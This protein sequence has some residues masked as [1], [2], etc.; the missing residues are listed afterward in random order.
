MADRPFRN[1][2]F[3]TLRSAYAV[4][5]VGLLVTPG[6]SEA[7]S[8]AELLRR[9]VELLVELQEADGQ[10]AY[11]GV[12]RVARQIPVG[13]RVGGTAIVA[14]TLLYA[15][16]NDSAAKAAIARAIPFVLK[17]LDD[18][19]MVPSTEEGYD[20]RVW[21]HACA[22][23]FL[24]HLRAAGTAGEHAAAVAAWI[25]K[26][27]ATLVTEE[28]SG[29]GWNYASRQRHASFV[30]APVTQALLLA[31]SQGEKVP[32]EVLSRARKVLEA[33]RSSVG[34]FAYSGTGS[35]GRPGDQVPGSAARSAVCE[36]TL[37]LLGGGSLDAVRA[38]ID[39]FHTNWDE[40]KKRHQQTG[41]HVP[42]YMIAPYYFYYGHRYA[43]QAIEMLPE[44][45]RAKER[46]RL[47]SVILK[48][49]D[50]DGTW[51]DR[52]FPR[53]RAYGTAMC[54]VAL[55]G[56]QVPLPPRF[57]PAEQ[58][59]QASKTADRGEDKAKID[60]ERLVGTWNCVSGVNDG[61]P[62][63]EATV[64]QLRLTLTKDRYKTERGEEVLFDSTYTIDAQKQPKHMNI[65]GTEGENK[66]KAAQGIYALDAD[67]L[68]IC[69]TMPGKD[70][71]TA[72]ESKPGSAATLVIWKRAK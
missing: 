5:A 62:I 65:I 59:V 38:A 44:S 15:A 21:G 9:S 13:Y 48:T 18:P 63:G 43:A 42:P 53:S 58:L 24:C 31:R 69:Y 7:P 35:R 61:K 14:D 30:T 19:R 3:D 55:L 11:E 32:E 70:R 50:T 23:E 10:W 46:D 33:S 17:H 54:L 4:F 41:T 67:A 51:N 71:P 2:V 45:E 29:G 26:L 60:A 28:I 16:R 20:V 72:F 34:A 8:R 68:M 25:P 36:V 52:V 37:M 12:Y 6:R 49:R 40:L 22:L 56:E 47:L 64:K 1:R 66:G 27:V 57:V 39:I